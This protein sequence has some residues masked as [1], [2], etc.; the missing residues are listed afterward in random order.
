MTT[1]ITVDNIESSALTQISGGPKI[2]TIQS[3]NSTWGILANNVVSTSGGFL[4]I[5]GSGF[6]NP[7]Q[8]FVDTTRATSISF[9]NTSILNVTLPARSAGSYLVYVV[10]SDGAFA[11]KINGVTY[12]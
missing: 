12:A 10:R 6:S 8:V 5:T 11:S 9:V 3:A 1:K 2:S 7:M 4:V